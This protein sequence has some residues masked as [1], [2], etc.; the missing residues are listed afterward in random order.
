MKAILTSMLA[1]AALL[2]ATPTTASAETAFAP[3]HQSYAVPVNGE[4]YQAVVTSSQYVVVKAF[5][6]WC[7]PC[8]RLNPIYEELADQYAEQILFT[9]LDC[10]D[11]AEL[12]QQLN[13]TALPT[14]L[15]IKDGS[16]VGKSLGYVQKAT[17]E[18][19]MLKAFKDI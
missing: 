6:D 16:V 19:R 4:T 14:V 13:I 8:N 9:T 15:F 11:Q 12:A 17:L 1:G 7:G 3:E 2:L 5:A 18:E 10:V